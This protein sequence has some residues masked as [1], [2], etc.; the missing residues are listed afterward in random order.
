MIRFETS[1]GGFTVEL[2]PKEAPVTVENFLRYVDVVMPD[3]QP[4]NVIAR[5]IDA[6]TADELLMMRKVAQRPLPPQT[7]P[8]WIS[9]AAHDLHGFD[10]DTVFELPLAGHSVR[11]NVRGIW[12][13]Y[14]QRPGGGVVLD[15][16]VPTDRRWSVLHHG[17]QQMLDHILSSRA[18]H[19]CFRGVEIHN[20][21]VG[22]ELIAYARHVS[23]SA[24]AHAPVVATF[25]IGAE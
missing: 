8:V 17:R 1:H 14:E 25:D 13:D 22:D 9:E 4:L 3:G 11:A 10:V 16:T 7:V 5:A 23:V 24:S 19:G 18:L 12:R 20:E 21:A 15:R 2:F 6:R